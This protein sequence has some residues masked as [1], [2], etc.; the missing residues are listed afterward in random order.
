MIRGVELSRA[1]G[2]QVH[3][4]RKEVGAYSVRKG[5]DPG[6]F[7]GTLA[8]REP[9]TGLAARKATLKVLLEAGFEIEQDTGDDFIPVTVDSL[10]FQPSPE[11]VVN[12]QRNSGWD[13][14]PDPI[15]DLVRRS[16]QAEFGEAVE[17]QALSAHLGVQAGEI[18]PRMKLGT[19]SAPGID[20]SW[21]V[22]RDGRLSGISWVA[23][24]AVE[25][26]NDALA[27]EL[28]PAM[29]VAERAEW[30]VAGKVVSAR[31]SVGKPGVVVVLVI[32]AD[33]YDEF[34]GD[35]E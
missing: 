18:R 27:S 2:L 24:R 22:D 26:V 32:A 33:A 9:G 1:W 34:L 7:A 12:S 6:R 35:E 4:G 16:L 31:G 10:G 3:E 17:P 13:E 29:P 23:E 15:V 11:A 20:G 5:E 21:Y 14:G 19:M 25:A 28:G 8:S 30:S